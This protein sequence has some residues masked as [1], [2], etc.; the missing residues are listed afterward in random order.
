MEQWL[1]R[2]VKNMRM[3]LRMYIDISR[4]DDSYI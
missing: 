4:G 3:L 2:F 1:G